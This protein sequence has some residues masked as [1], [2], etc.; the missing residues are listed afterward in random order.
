MNQERVK[1]NANNSPV[2]YHDKDG[3]QIDMKK[4]PTP[5]QEDCF[6]QTKKEEAVLKRN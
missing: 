4:E 6:K 5:F 1:V 3:K 2:I